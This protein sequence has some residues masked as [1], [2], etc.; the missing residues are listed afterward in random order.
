MKKCFIS[1]KAEKWDKCTD[2]PLASIL[3]ILQNNANDKQ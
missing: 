3:H 2:I 1:S